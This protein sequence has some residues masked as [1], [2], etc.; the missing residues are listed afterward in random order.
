MQVSVATVITGVG[1]SVCPRSKRKNDLAIN[2]KLGMIIYSRLP[3][4]MGPE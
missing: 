4:C 3:A 2:N 1:D